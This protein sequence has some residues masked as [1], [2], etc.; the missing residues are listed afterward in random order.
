MAT[1]TEPDQHGTRSRDKKAEKDAM[2]APAV[3]AEEFDGGR[4]MTIL[5]HLQE[6]RVRLIWCCI[7]LVVGVGISL[8]F[9]NE[10]M[11]FLIQPA[12]DRAPDAHIVSTRV[13]GNFSIYFKVALLGGLILAMPMF[14]YQT[15][16]FVLPGLTPQ[17]KRWVIPIVCGI[18]VSFAA[19]VAFAYYVT[20]P[21]AMDFLL[22]FNKDTAEN[23]I[24]ITDYIDFTTRLLFW[25]GVTFE[26]PLFI[27]ALAR[28]GLITGRKLLSW[29]RFAI[30]GAFVMSAFVTPTIDPVTQTLVAA[31][32]VILWLIGVALAFMFGRPR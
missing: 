11:D 12:R 31:P 4:P 23:F 18:F 21:P 5:E 20:L 9:T 26:T 19:G 14:V 28:F 22:N 6:L 2:T 1:S 8:F 10:I 30:P 32:I 7:G 16:M 29:W 3:P 24:N 25:V 15:L 17:E 27:L 13:L